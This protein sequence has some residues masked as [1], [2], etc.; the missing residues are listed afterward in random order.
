[1]N[2]EQF[3][4]SFIFLQMIKFQILF[5]YESDDKLISTQFLGQEVAWVGAVSLFRSDIVMETSLSVF[6][7]P[8]PR[9]KG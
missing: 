9:R 7:N 3:G 6:L 1:M 2:E 4:R 8:T 5:L